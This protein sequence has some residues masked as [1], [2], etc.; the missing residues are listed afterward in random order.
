MWDLT[1]EGILMAQDFAAAYK[2]LSWEAVFCSPLRRSV[3]TARPLCEAVGLKAQIRDGL[4]EISYGQWRAG[5]LL[6][7]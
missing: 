4:R 1:P 6:R 7:R 5:K 2:S 3:A